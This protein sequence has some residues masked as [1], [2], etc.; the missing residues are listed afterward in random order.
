MP[1]ELLPPDPSKDGWY[2][3]WQKDVGPDPWLWLASPRQ[4][5]VGPWTIKPDEAALHGILVSPH[6]MMARWRAD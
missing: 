4:W 2:W 5:A 3:V 1:D 6:P